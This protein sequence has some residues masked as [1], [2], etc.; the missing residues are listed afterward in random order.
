[1]HDALTDTR[2]ELLVYMLLIGRGTLRMGRIIGLP[3]Y[4]G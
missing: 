4:S 2:C 1:M 3:I